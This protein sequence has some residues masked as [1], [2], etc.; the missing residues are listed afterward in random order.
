MIN[1]FTYKEKHKIQL[2]LPNSSN[3]YMMLYENIQFAGSI[4]IEDN[5]QYIQYGINYFIKKI[6]GQIR[7]NNFQLLKVLALSTIVEK[8]IK[9]YEK[10]TGDI[11]NYL[12]IIA[13]N[14]TRQ[15]FKDSVKYLQKKLFLTK[16]V[17]SYPFK[18]VI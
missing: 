18:L 5:N 7:S 10:I 16:R 8:D 6:K 3:K 14:I 11:E 13:T 9:S 15:R 12:R 17:F 2:L 1:K 4:K